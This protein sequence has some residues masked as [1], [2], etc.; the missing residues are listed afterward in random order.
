MSAAGPLWSWEDSGHGRWYWE[1]LG[2]ANYSE[3]KGWAG[4]EQMVKGW[5][6]GQQVTRTSCGKGGNSQHWEGTLVLVTW[7]GNASSSSLAGIAQRCTA[8]KYHFS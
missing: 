7:C 6:G 2:R 1:K 4:A 5:G 8:I 3:E